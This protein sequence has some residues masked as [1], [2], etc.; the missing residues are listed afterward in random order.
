MNIKSNKGLVGTD[1]SVSIIILILF[2]AIITTIFYQ[3]GMS[4]LKTTRNSIATDCAVNIIEAIKLMSYEE[5][6]NT[7]INKEWCEESA[8]IDIPDG[9]NV[10]IEKIVDEEKKELMQEFKVTVSYTVQG[11]NNNISMTTLKISE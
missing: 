1:I 8:G 7:D 10:T 2:V 6:L 3:I 9:Y 4:N 5:F 11:Q